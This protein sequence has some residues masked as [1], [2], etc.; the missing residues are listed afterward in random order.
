MAVNFPLSLQP[1]Q[2]LLLVVVGPDAGFQVE[3]VCLMPVQ[4]Y[5]QFLPAVFLI[6]IKSFKIGVVPVAFKGNGKFIDDVKRLLLSNLDIPF[7]AR[8]QGS[9][10]EV[11]G[12][13]V[14][15]GEASLS[16]KKIGF[17]MQAGVVGL[18][19]DLDCSVGQL[20]QGQG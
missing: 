18:V 12:T 10:G 3:G 6:R 13:D 17:G 11:G 1:V 4:F 5:L 19:V 8:G 14:G 15:G 9:A 2:D 20:A 7:Q 16:F